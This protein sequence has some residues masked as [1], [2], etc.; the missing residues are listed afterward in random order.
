[1]LPVPVRRVLAFV[2]LSSAAMLPIA[3]ASR[4]QTGAVA[5]AGIGALMGQAIGGNT[6]ATLIGTGVGVGIGYII[7]NEM[8]RSK[9]EE[10]SRNQ[11]RQIRELEQRQQAQQAELDRQRN[12]RASAPPPP[13]P[14]PPPAPRTAPGVVHTEV[15]SLGD[16]RWRVVSVN[17]SDAVPEFASF[18]VDFRSN[19][20][21]LTTR[22]NRDGSIVSGNESFRVV[23]DTL[24]VNET[25][26][27]I[28]ARF[29]QSANQLFLSADRFSAVLE[30]LPG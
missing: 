13:P 7:G 19:G 30:R 12:A 5:G 2:A 25:G 17:P 11:D 20:R 26:Y 23:G 27:L 4:A 29:Q 3:C 9:A 15:G 10:M 28:N 24:I 18:V 1:M 22:T 21:V 6:T 8:D 16:T 14:P